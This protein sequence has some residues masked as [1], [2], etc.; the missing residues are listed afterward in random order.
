MSSRVIFHLITD[1]SARGGTERNLTS[2]LLGMDGQHYLCSLGSLDKNLFEDLQGKENIHFCPALHCR[3]NLF[4]LITAPFRLAFIIRKIKPNILVGWMYHANVMLALSKCFFARE[5]PL[6]WNVR[7]SLEFFQKERFS[8]RIAIKLGALL[9]RLPNVIIYNSRQSRNQHRKTGYSSQN[10][11]VIPNG[12]DTEL[13]SPP[14]QP[15]KLN[16]PVRVGTLG[17][18][19]PIK[20][21]Q[22][23]IR[24]ATHFAGKNVHFSIKGKGVEDYSTEINR[25]GMAEIFT[26]DDNEDHPE[27]F[28]KSLDIFVLPSFSEGFSN[29]L[30]EAMATGLPC[31]ATNV[32][33]ADFIIGGAGLVIP[34]NDEH[35]LIAAIETQIADVKSGSI[36]SQEIREKITMRF[37]LQQ[38]INNYQQMIADYCSR[39]VS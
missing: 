23:L 8:T 10:D 24:A 7:H 11:Q 27:T 28:L 6:L 14:D 1:Y 2:L 9:S 39:I 29:V 5:L 30:C 20:N 3:S 34:S 33:D 32:G 17:R 25:L 12:I 22:L 26:L 13:F 37:A 21:H 38:F 15:R 36:N 18:S 31:I 35:A 19:H 4:N 16:D